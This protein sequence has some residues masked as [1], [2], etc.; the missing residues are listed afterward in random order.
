MY[1]ASS[2]CDDRVLP[3]LYIQQ[4]LVERV[5]EF[6][7]LGSFVADTH[8]LGIY[9]DVQRR[10]NEASWNV[11]EVRKSKPRNLSAFNVA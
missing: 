3:D 4:E 5:H 7:Y 1:V 2:G 11:F 6:V 9:K 10:V 8:N